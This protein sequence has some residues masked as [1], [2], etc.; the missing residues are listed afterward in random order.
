MSVIQELERHAALIRD[1]KHDR[2][3]PGVPVQMSPAL[4][5]GEG[6]AQ[7]DLYLIVESRVPEDYV[8]VLQP[9]DSD[10]Q[11]VPGQ[12][13]GAKHCLDSLEGVKMYR[14]NLWSSES[15]EGPHLVL[16]QDRVVLHPTHGA[17]TIPAG[18]SVT[19]YYQREYDAEQKRERRA[20]D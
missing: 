11:L 19:C 15:L 2:I 18:M 9:Q 1:G 14:P 6:V 8:E 13:V 16:S 12:T 20:L 17:V 4:E 10:R 7:G 5:P 3:G